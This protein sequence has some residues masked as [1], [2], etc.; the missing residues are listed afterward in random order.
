[1]FVADMAVSYEFY[2][3][4]LGFSVAFVYGDPPFYRQVFRDG[5]RLNLRC[6]AKPPIDPQLRV[7]EDLLGGFKRSSQ[8]LQV[9]GC[10]DPSKA[11][12]P[13]IRTAAA[14]VTGTT[15]SSEAI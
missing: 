8:H 14:A 3:K 2:T 10:D 1:L 6:L 15:A 7:N 11:S 12:I 5:A 9:G 4:Q 13:A